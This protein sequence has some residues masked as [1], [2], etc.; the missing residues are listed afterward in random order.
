MVMSA[1]SLFRVFSIRFSFVLSW[2]SANSVLR[3]SNVNYNNVTSLLH[4]IH[5][6]A[7]WHISSTTSQCLNYR[8]RCH[9]RA[10]WTHKTVLI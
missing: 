1:L 4:S 8:S 9:S 6:H 3:H 10:T 5:C 2:M 7:Q